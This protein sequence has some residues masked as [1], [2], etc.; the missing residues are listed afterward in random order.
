MGAELVGVSKEARDAADGVIT[1]PMSGFAQSLNISVA[2]A[3]IL[4]SL[5]QRIRHDLDANAAL[6]DDEREALWAM[7]LA[8]EEAMRTGIRSRS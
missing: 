5:S 6:P 7:W 1:I 8:R 3:V 4:Y 2:A